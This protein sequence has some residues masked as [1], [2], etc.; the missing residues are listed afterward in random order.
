MTSGALAFTG[1]DGSFSL[2]G[3][4]PG[5]ATVQAELEEQTS[6]L[7]EVELA[8]RLPEPLHLVL[9]EKRTLTLTVRVVDAAGSPAAGAFVFLHEEGKGQRLLTTAAD[10]RATVALE[11]P[12]APRL[13]AAAYANGAWGFGSWTPRKAAED[14]LTVQ[15]T[16]AGSLLVHSARR[17]G[18]PAIVTAEGWD[19]SW[20][21][22]LL[23]EPPVLS[24]EQP[25]QLTGLP[26][27]PY[28]V[29]LDGT[30]VIVAVD[31]GQVGAGT[32]E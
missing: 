27:G 5:K 12:L 17:Q 6:P 10:G 3:L 15:L 23:G 2:T 25:L 30:S 9:G 28:R 4:Q 19:L 26:A 16:G 29:S 32:I 14:G 8:D 21:L 31:P 24:V 20:L 18:S 7:A 11:P 22:R 13:R 1:A